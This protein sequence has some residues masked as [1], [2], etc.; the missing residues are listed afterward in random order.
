MSWRT[1]THG[2]PFVVKTWCDYLFRVQSLTDQYNACQ[3]RVKD[4]ENQM[5]IT[6]QRLCRAGK[7]LS[8]VSV[9]G[10]RWTV[11]AKAIQDDMSNLLSDV[12]VAAG[13][14]YS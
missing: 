1:W 14:A 12:L 3:E 4:L 5:Q 11:D 6:E 8:G 9:E 2:V 7:V 10:A 13:T